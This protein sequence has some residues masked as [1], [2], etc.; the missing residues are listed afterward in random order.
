[1]LAAVLVCAPAHGAD[2]PPVAALPDLSGARSLG[3][4]ASVATASSNEGI[5]VNPGA[6]A[7]NR[8]YTVELRGLLERRGA[9]SVG[10]LLSG[11][12]VDA[13]TSP[14]AAGVAWGKVLDGVHDGSIV[15]LA[16][17]GT[18]SPGLTFGVAGKYLHL[19]GPRD[20]Q[21]VT[22]DAGLLWRVGRWVSLGA[23]GYNLLP[24]GNE[25][26]APRSV[27][28]GVALGSDRFLQVT[29]DWAANLDASPTRNRYAVGAELLL[30]NFPL[31]AG[32]VVEEHV[33]ADDAR[34]WTAGA[35]VVQDRVG[36]DLG[37][38]QSLDDSSARMISASLKVYFI[39]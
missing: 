35:G 7:A 10:Q 36:L 6:I 11:S 3:L 20:V 8:R 18:V 28:A 33:E 25:R 9:E 30:A 38:R 4:G 22:V 16:L 1:M 13:L 26:V 21:A 2:S 27:A 15:D 32:Y 29:A 24:I 19:D 31:R 12:V 34:W 39:Q 37:Y 14:V 17:G 5:F 23:A